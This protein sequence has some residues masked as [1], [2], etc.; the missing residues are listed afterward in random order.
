MKLRLALLTTVALGGQALANTCAAPTSRINAPGPGVPAS[1][2]VNSYYPVVPV[3]ANGVGS[4]NTTFSVGPALACGGCGT[5]AA[6]VAGDM[7]LLIQNQAPQLE[8]TNTNI[9]GSGVA[10]NNGRGITTRGSVARMGFYRVISSNV[11]VGAGGSITVRNGD[12]NTLDFNFGPGAT[13]DRLKSGQVIIVPQVANLTL[14]GTLTAPAFQNAPSFV[15]TG[16]TTS[17]QLQ[18]V[19]GIVALDVAGTLDFNGQTIDVSGKG[20]RG[21]GGRQF[22]GYTNT[23]KLGIDVAN[24]DYTRNSPGSGINS[25]N[26]PPGDGTSVAYAHGFKGEGIAGTP[27]FVNNSGTVVD[28]GALANVGTRDGYNGGAL[29]RGAPGNAGGGGTD[30]AP[31]PATTGNTQNTGGGGGAGHGDGGQGGNFGG[32]GN[33]GLGGVGVTTAVVT[34][35][36]QAG[37]NNNGTNDAVGGTW[38]MASLG[39]GGGAGSAND[40]AGTAAWAASGAAGGG[41]VIIRAN[42]ITGTGIVRANGANATVGPSGDAAGGGGGGGW[43]IIAASDQSLVTAPSLLLEARGGDGGSTTGVGNNSGPGG[44]GGGGATA[45]STNIA[46]GVSSVVTGGSAGSSVGT[47]TGAAAGSS[48]NAQTFG[49]IYFVGGGT[50]AA[51]GASSRSVSSG[52]ECVPIVRKSYTPTTAASGADRTFSISITN[53][54]AGTYPKAIGNISFVDNY[55]SG[56]VNA[57]TPALSNSGT[58][59]CGTPIE[60]LTPGGT[61]FSVSDGGNIPGGSTCTWTMQVTA[62]GSGT[63]TNTIAQ[64]AVSVKIAPATSSEVTTLNETPAVASLNFPSAVTG[65]KTSDVVSDPLNNTTNP[66]R[67][68]GATVDYTITITNNSGSAVDNNTMVLSDALPFASVKLFVGNLSGGQPFVFTPNASNLTCASCISYSNLASPNVANDADWTYVPVADGDS[69]DANVRHIRFK[70]LGSMA[71]GSSIA[72]RYRTIVK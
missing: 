22:T 47:S 15:T 48:G 51:L 44:G 16:S 32:V 42:A 9:Y 72:I 52:A 10:G 37:G 50:L 64:D 4:G 8:P 5:P 54:N 55:P 36:N 17:G 13:Q 40:A 18:P 34:A 26:T 6:I 27:R 56:V 45:V 66:K 3:G 71:N 21:G 65:S 12:Y 41:I 60:S 30:N 43:I 67:I 24:T 58:G 35:A 53:P 39:G 70:T 14:N 57:A 46:G 19:G 29:G 68:P 49:S 11:T 28:H 25:N 59:S 38:Q 31:T 7:V 2:V 1:G 33:P 61:T 63:L 62:T 69:A 20:F 23:V